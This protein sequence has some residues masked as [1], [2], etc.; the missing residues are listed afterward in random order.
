MLE[1]YAGAV[2]RDEGE[3]GMKS[4]VGGILHDGE[5]FCLEG[6]AVVEKGRV[7]GRKT[8]SRSI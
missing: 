6:C 8:G 5:G 3:R 1:P 2:M 4:V 7:E